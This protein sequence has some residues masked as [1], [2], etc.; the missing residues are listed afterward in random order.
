MYWHIRRPSCKHIKLRDHVGI[1]V[2]LCTNDQ[3]LDKIF[4]RE[5]GKGV[6]PVRYIDLVFKNVFSYCRGTLLR[7]Y[8]A[9]ETNC[10]EL[11][12]NALNKKTSIRGFYGDLLKF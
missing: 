12:Y 11:K 4:E 7:A 6:S 2:L 5:I 1:G 3:K 9:E 8:I 10:V